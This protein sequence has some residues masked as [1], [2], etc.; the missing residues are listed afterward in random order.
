MVLSLPQKRRLQELKLSYRD[1]KKKP[2]KAEVIFG[3]LRVQGLGFWG[4]G[5]A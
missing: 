4:L 3:R 5:S 2:K 1:P